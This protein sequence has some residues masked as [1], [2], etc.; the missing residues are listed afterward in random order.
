MK[1]RSTSEAFDLIEEAFP[2]VRFLLLAL[3]GD[4]KAQHWLEN[5]SPGTGLFARLL[6]GDETVVPKMNNG[7]PGRMDDLFELVDN[8]DLTRLL[9]ERRPALHL[10]FGALR[11]DIDA[12][13]ALKRDGP[14][15]HRQLTPLRQAYARYKKHENEGPIEES[16]ADMGCLVGEMHLRAGEFEKAIEAFTRAIETAPSA[17][18]YEGR[19]RAYRGLAEMDMERAQLTRSRG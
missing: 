18:L 1:N 19:A 6:G 12:A 8:D 7:T 4:A 16:A 11:G 5:N 15:Y 14:T 10:L 3:D 17:D 13:R 2:Q 9:Q